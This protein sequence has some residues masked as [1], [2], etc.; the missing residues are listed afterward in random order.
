MQRYDFLAHLHE[1]LAP[2]T[3]F[4]IGVQSG[5]SLHLAARAELALGV[6]PDP[7]ITATGNQVIYRMTS[8]SYF[9]D[10][11]APLPKAKKI[12]FG[13]IDGDHRY[14]QALRD[15]YNVQRACHADSVIAFDDVLPYNQDVGGR[16]MVAGHWAGDVWRVDEVIG[17]NQPDL[18]RVLVDVEPTG[19]LLVWNLDPEFYPRD[20][21]WS[22]SPAIVPDEVINRSYAMQPGDALALVANHY[23]A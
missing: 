21:T 7:W 9:A 23:G 14:E 10:D 16:E 15:F 4:E 20:S 8:D 17:K 12:D 5:M 13:F 2:K 18:I 22:S 19:L 11:F 3:Y 1:I 6:D